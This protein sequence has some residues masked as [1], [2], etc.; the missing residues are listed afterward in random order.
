MTGNEA[1]K[2]VRAYRQDISGGEPTPLL[3]EGVIPRRFRLTAKR[4][5]R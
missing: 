2:A 5:S 1:G 4:F 3:Q